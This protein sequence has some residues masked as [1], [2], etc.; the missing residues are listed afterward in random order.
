[1]TER[2]NCDVTPDALARLQAENERLTVELEALRAAK[3]AAAVS[4]GQAQLKIAQL[5]TELW[6]LQAP[7]ER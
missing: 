4:Y 5:E 2:T 1:M 6:R 7:G 3:R